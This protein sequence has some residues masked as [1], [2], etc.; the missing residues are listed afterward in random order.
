M[1]IVMLGPICAGSMTILKRRILR[2][3]SPGERL[4][5][6]STCKTIEIGEI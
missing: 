2:L 6:L 1:I 5:L 3:E 4:G